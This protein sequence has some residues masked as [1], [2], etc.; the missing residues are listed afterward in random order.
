MNPKS[1][2]FAITI[3]DPSW[4]RPSSLPAGLVY[5]CG[6]QELCPT[7]N[8]VHWQL[9]ARTINNVRFGSVKKYLNCPSAHVEIARNAA[10]ARS[11]CF[12]SETRHSTPF[13]LGEWKEIGRPK[14]ASD[15]ALRL[16]L[17]RRISEIRTAEMRI[18]FGAYVPDPPFYYRPNTPVNYRWC[19]LHEDMDNCWND[20]E[21]GNSSDSD[22]VNI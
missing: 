17:Y 11:Y 19:S 4:I 9:Y 2:N 15:D 22:V 7:S 10:A 12:K 3:F 8:K 21:N 13:E 16:E 14:K 1:R 6:Q 20:F 18:F 5:L